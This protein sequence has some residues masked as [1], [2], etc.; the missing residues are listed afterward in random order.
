MRLYKFARNPGSRIAIASDQT[1]QQLPQEPGVTWD[2]I[3][4]VDFPADFKAAGISP[5][6]VLESVENMG[7]FF[8]PEVL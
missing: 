7:Y 5:D 8:V 3:G 2:L 4:Q 6:E 1:G